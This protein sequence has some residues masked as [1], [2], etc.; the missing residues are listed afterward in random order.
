M[1]TV[2]QQL[3]HTKSCPSGSSWFLLWLWLCGSASSL[4]SVWNRRLQVVKYQKEP[5]RGHLW[6]CSKR[7]S[8]FNEENQQVNYALLV[9]VSCVTVHPIVL[10]STWML[11]HSHMFPNLSHYLYLFLF[12]HMCVCFSQ[13]F[14][15][16]RDS[17][18][19]T[20]LFLIGLSDKTG[21]FLCC[22][23]VGSYFR[24][25]SESGGSPCKYVWPQTASAASDYIPISFWLKGWT[26][27]VGS[28]RPMCLLSG[29]TF[30]LKPELSVR[31]GRKR[32]DWIPGR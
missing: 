27:R 19:W 13:H 28:W 9:C 25:M 17:G 30:S 16:Q 26:R 22:W 23:E 32:M 4:L 29:W 3:S 18:G 6:F 20:R 7:R 2:A 31:R 8:S 12:Y 5:D 14:S 11:C 21:C 15:V 24:G 1:L 10:C